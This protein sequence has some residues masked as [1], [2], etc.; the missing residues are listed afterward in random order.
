MQNLGV[1]PSRDKIAKFCERHHIGK[2]S[3]FGSVLREDFVPRSDIVVLVEFEPGDAVLGRHHRDT[4]N[5]KEVFRAELLPLYLGLKSTRMTDPRE[6]LAFV[7]ARSRADLDTDHMLGLPWCGC[8]KSLAG[9]RK[10]SD[11]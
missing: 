4:E 6:A 3:L 10:A 7:Q 5:K 2:L 8:S 9:L 1:R 11:I